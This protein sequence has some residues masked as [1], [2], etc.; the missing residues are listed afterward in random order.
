MN[1]KV[2]V[3]SRKGI[4]DYRILVPSILIISIVSILFSIFESKS[5]NILNSI[6]DY[7]V[8][9][10][11]WGYIWYAVILFIATLFFSFSKYGNVVL[12]K[13]QDKPR[14]T[15]FQYAS[16]LIATG[17]GSTVM[18][19]GIIQWTDVTLD[20][21]AGVTPESTEALLWGSSY[22][23]FIWSP[24]IFSIFVVAAPAIAYVLHV[25]KKPLL[26]ISEACRPVLGDKII[27]GIGG[28][29]LD[30]IFLLSILSGASVTLGFSTPLVTYSLASLFDVEV[31]FGLTLLVIIVWVL[32]FTISAY[33]GIDKGIKKL[34]TFNMYLA[35]VF[36]LCI[37]IVGPGIFI[38]NYFTENISFL[39][40]HYIDMSLYTNSLNLGETSFM[41]RNTVFWIAYNSTWG[42]LGSVFI[43]KISRGRT[44][45][46]MILTYLLAP[47]LVS[48]VV[49]GVL[50]GLGVHRYINGD[51]PVLDIAK[52]D[53]MLAIPEILSSLPLGII[54]IIVFIFITT[55]FLATTLDSTTYTI[56]SYTSTKNM[57]EE[58]PS[59]TLTIIVAIILTMV[60]LILMRIGGLAPL[61]VLSGLMGIPIIFV[62]FLTIYSVKKMMDEDKAWKYNIRDKQ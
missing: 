37:M 21:P 9:V 2:D 43:A 5:L 26:R 38:I 3:R 57:S 15:L 32:L 6:F 11:S 50:G 39:F 10:F 58:E 53:P 51:I 62:Q 1:K 16:I 60:T 55:I 59:K 18:R 4:S 8:Q 45:K 14:F 40:K 12:G 34:S 24:L 36:A 56:A 42:M 54:A 13:P 31:T 33:L 49:T 41:E 52:E 29:I 23:M 47:T 30:I 27:D 7:I 46:E 25:R 19:T 17:L 35:G 48:W 28:K 61:E 44:I 22:S 20:P